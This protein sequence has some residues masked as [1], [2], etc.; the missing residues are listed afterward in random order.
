MID[1]AI[2]TSKPYQDNRIADKETARRQGETEVNKGIDAL[3]AVRNDFS[4][5]TNHLSKAALFPRAL[6]SLQTARTSYSST[7][8]VYSRVAANPAVTALPS[9]IKLTV[10]ESM[11][12]MVNIFET[13]LARSREPSTWLY[14]FVALVL[15]AFIA[16][17]GAL[18]ILSYR[19][20]SIYI[21]GTNV[22]QGW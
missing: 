16:C 1:S 5:A 22:R 6:M 12:S 15:D 3:V 18:A 10:F 4:N 17:C 19:S 21:E 13:L 8:S 14:L 2:K 20:R 7:H 11:L 9:V